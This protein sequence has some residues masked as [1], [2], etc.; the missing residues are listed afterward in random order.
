MFPTNQAGRWVCLASALGL[1]A[2]AGVA[3]C[4]HTATPP[5]GMPTPTVGVTPA[6]RMDVPIEVMPNGTTHAIEEVTIRARVRGFLTERRFTEGAMVHK[7]DLLLVIDEEPYKVALQAAQ[8]RRIEADST[9]RKAEESKEREIAAAQLEL[10]RAQ[11]NLA[12]IQERRN[13]NLVSRKAGSAEELDKAEADRRRWEAQIEADQAHVAQAQANFNAGIASG[14]AQV[15]EAHAS[16]R[17]AELNLGYCRMSAPID[18]RIGQAL[19]KVG[20]LVGPD[21]MGGGAFTDL[22]TIQQLDPMGVD[23][24]LSSTDLE[25]ITDLTASGL[26]AHL[27]R[28]SPTGPKDHP[29]AGRVY[30]IDNTVD[31]TTSTF[32]AKVSIPNPAGKLLPGEYVKVR[33]EVDRLA[34]ALV[35]PAPA[36]VESDAGTVVNVVL[37]GKVATRRVVTGPTF[38]GMRVIASGLEPEA[39]VIVEGLQ[40]VRPGAPVKV[41]PAAVARSGRAETTRVTR[42][43]PSAAPRS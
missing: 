20:N 27:T 23:L 42:A 10:D 32:L 15:A 9:L 43:A 28:P 19:V 13:R 37:D 36:V 39:S 35:V 22:A 31:E 5:M 40:M 41:E 14:R 11:L 33:M 16:I 6:R 2:L 18:G 34:E 4:G 29:H 26:P 38:D 25:R 21:A 17:D 8:A 12:E 24:R 1:A 30:F 7:G 3:G